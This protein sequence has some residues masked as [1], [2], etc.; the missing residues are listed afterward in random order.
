M[1]RVDFESERAYDDDRFMVATPPRPLVASV[2]STGALGPAV[3]AI[4]LGTA[5]W[6]QVAAFVEAFA[7]FGFAVGIGI[8]FV[9]SERRRVGFYG[10]LAGAMSGITAVAVGLSFAVGRISPTL[11]RAHLRLN[12]LGFLG[13][14][15][16]GIAYQFYPPAVGTLSGAS[17][18]TALTSIRCV[19]GG[20]LIQV[21]GLTGQRSLITIT[22]ELVALTGILLYTYLLFDVLK[23]W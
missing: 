11:V 22:G 3:L 7:V 6:M 12:L 13:L 1:V 2:L 19:G 16:I 5:P 17:D 18:R 21:I 15:I 10:V 9:R 8:L 14:T 23:T 4:H 20:L